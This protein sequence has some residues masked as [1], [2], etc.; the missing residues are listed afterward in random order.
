MFERAVQD[1]CSHG[2]DYED[3]DGILQLAQS[4]SASV[5]ASASAS[6]SASV[7]ASMNASAN[8]SVNTSANASGDEYDLCDLASDSDSMHTAPTFS[9]GDDALDP[10]AE[11]RPPSGQQDS[12]LHPRTTHRRLQE[13]SVEDALC[14]PAWRTPGG[15][16]PTITPGATATAAANATTPP[17]W[18]NPFAKQGDGSHDTV[19]LALAPPAL[20]PRG[21]GHSTPTQGLALN[22]SRT[23]SSCFIQQQSRRSLR[24][25]I[26]EGSVPQ[27]CKQGSGEVPCRPKFCSADTPLRKRSSADVPR[28]SHNSAD[29]SRCSHNSADMSR[30]NHNSAD[31]SKGGRASTDMSRYARG[32]RCKHSSISSGSSSSL[33]PNLVQPETFSH[34]SCSSIL[35][36]LYGLD[37]YISSDLDARSSFSTEDGFSALGSGSTRHDSNGSGSGAGTYPLLP[38]QTYNIP[39]AL[40]DLGGNRAGASPT[41]APPPDSNILLYSSS[42]NSRSDLS[43]RSYTGAQIPFPEDFVGVRKRQKSFIEQSLASSF[44]QLT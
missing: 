37:K 41:T 4:A 9:L 11:S 15:V 20:T 8:A 10:L 29:M 13:L 5:S 16:T 28:C 27:R 32:P 17:V 21:N 34:S 36:H 44:S 38:G 19:T 31:M 30:C 1:P 3:D 39:G 23:N 7:N 43:L 2:C 40:P 6:A 26:G 22:R 42:H 18:T 33:Y 24:S 25:S 12:P 35:T 14:R